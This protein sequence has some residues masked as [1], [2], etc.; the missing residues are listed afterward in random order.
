WFDPNDSPAERRLVQKLDFFILTYAFVGFWVCSAQVHVTRPILALTS[1]QVLYIDR[2]VLANAYVSGMREELELF[3]NQY[4]QLNA[5]Y[6][7]GYCI[8]MIPATLLI[9]KYKAQLVIP[10]CM[11]MWGIWSICCFQ[12]K[13]FRELI[14]YR[15]LMALSQGPYFC[16]IHYILGSWYRTDEI[17]RRA[18]IFYVSS[19]VG[20]MTTG[21]LAARIYTNLDG[22]LGHAGWRWMYLVASFLTFPVAIWGLT[23]LPGT[24]RDGKRWFMTEHEFGLAKERMALQG[25]LDPKGLSLSK[26]S[27]KRF[28][29]RWH[30]WVLV[31]WNVQWTLGF[32]GMSSGALWL[33][34][35]TQYTTAQVNNFTAIS[36]SLGIIWIMSFAWVVDKFGRKAIIPTIAFA[37]R[38][39]FISKMHVTNLAL[40]RFAI[41]VNYI[42]VS[43]S[44]INYSLANIVCAADAEERAFV[45]SSMLAISTAFGAWVSILSFPTVEAPRFFKGY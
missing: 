25:R 5:V 33:R 31:P 45:I 32:L 27:L 4:I 36:P 20:T 37:F 35:Q 44:P 13:S 41:V 1:T 26:E 12:A 16:S 18:G 9:T 38:K 15:F 14:A 39:L 3:G 19:G 8:S 29:G 22:H 23:S 17:I 24:P 10:A 43:L 7:A 40:P 30:F 34:A 28:L 21:L 42:E 11:F 2:G 6:S